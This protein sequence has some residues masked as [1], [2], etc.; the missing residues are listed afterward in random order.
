MRI[1]I[2]SHK[3][4]WPTNGGY[5]T[6]GGFPIQIEAI[7]HLFD[8]TLLVVFE[9]GSTAHGGLRPLQGHNLR[10]EPLPEPPGH[11]IRR[12]LALV[13][14]V[15]PRLGR[16]WSSIRAADAV[17]AAVP[18]DLG[19]LSLMLA[20]LQRKPLFVRHCGTWGNR[21]TMADR[22]LAWLLPRIA[23]EHRVVM[24]TGGGPLPPSP[25]NPA[26]SW[27]FSTTLSKQE[28]SVLTHATPWKRGL[29][30]RLVTVGRLTEGKN[31]IAAIEALPEIRNTQTDV[32][33]EV[34]GDGP[35]RTGLE[36]RVEE[37]ELEEFVV[38]RGNIS[39]SEVLETLSRSHLFVFP[40]RVS[41]GFPKAVLEAMACGLPVIA[42][43]VS[44]LP[45]LLGSGAGF[46]IDDVE[47]ATIARAVVD[48]TTD[49]HRLEVMARK[50]RKTAEHYTLENWSQTIRERLELAWG[51]PLR[52]GASAS[53]AA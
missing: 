25:K 2:L 26:V 48:L 22:F 39:H 31:K 14:W 11:G 15:L 5:A 7:S 49:T 33:L 4:C 19:T 27:I 13:I 42:P 43:S 32:R 38:F 44:V 45:H 10:V 18:G 51:R 24:A 28:L 50:A 21:T 34:V 36:R 52:A 29:P 30:L 35:S 1:A 40:T 20:L 6:D 37:L 41:E 53:T 8:E 23:G 47:A 17:H 16:L 3:P 12:K 9:S 46:V